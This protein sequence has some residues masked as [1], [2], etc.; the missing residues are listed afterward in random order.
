MLKLPTANPRPQPAGT[1]RML[2]LPGWLCDP[3]NDGIVEQYD[4][5]T[6]AREYLAEH[7]EPD[8]Q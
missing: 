5:D 6:A 1:E 2:T 7:G 4:D 8:L 3:L